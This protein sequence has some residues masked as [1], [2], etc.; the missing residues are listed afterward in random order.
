MSLCNA[1]KIQPSM[2]SSRRQLFRLAL[3][4]CASTRLPS[5]ILRETDY[6]IYLSFFYDRIKLQKNPLKSYDFSGFLVVGGGLEPPISGICCGLDVGLA[7]LVPSSL[8]PVWVTVWASGNRCSPE[9]LHDLYLQ[10]CS[11]RIAH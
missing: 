8:N 7:P 9:V 10:L 3:P 11:L 4:K 1:G 5:F 6:S 2:S